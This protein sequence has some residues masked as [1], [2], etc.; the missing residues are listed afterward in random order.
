MH[1]SRESWKTSGNASAVTPLVELIFLRQTRR[2]QIYLL[3]ES[4]GG[5]EKDAAA[6]FYP[7]SAAANAIRAERE[8]KGPAAAVWRSIVK[9]V[10][11]D[12]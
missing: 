11:T 5:E 12:K 7:V 9:A 6:G 10:Q 2:P 1:H 4:H 3:C 8:P